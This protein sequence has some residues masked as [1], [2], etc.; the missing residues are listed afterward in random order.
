MNSKKGSDLTDKELGYLLEDIRK[1]IGTQTY[2]FNIA[3]VEIY[4]NTVCYFNEGGQLVASMSRQTYERLQ[5]E[6]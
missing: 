4:E 6:S 2:R 1:H 5:N 3:R